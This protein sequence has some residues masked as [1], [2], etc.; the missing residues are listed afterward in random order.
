MKSVLK[1]VTYTFSTFLLASVLITACGDDSSSNAT[2]QSLPNSSATI[3]QNPESSATE[4]FEQ[5]LPGSSA[6]E[7]TEQTFPVSSAEEQSSSSE[8]AKVLCHIV[9][10][11]KSGYEG[12]A[13]MYEYSDF[14]LPLEN[15]DIEAFPIGYEPCNNDIATVKGCYTSETYAEI[16]GE[17]N[18]EY[19]NSCESSTFGTIQYNGSKSPCNN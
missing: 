12:R 8:V 4:G 3:Q 7:G 14:C 11:F 1:S 15:C 9:Y 18:Y 13:V 17:C 19:K 6:S 16:I 5:Q 2:N 10:D